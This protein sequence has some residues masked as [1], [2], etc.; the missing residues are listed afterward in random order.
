MTN[1]LPYGPN[2]AAV[3]RFLQ[4]FA[5]LD[6]AQWQ[7]AADRFTQLETTPRFRAADQALAGAIERTDRGA[8]RDAVLGPLLQIVGG[9]EEPVAP[10][11]LSAALALVMRDVLDENHFATLFGA[12]APLV[13]DR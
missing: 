6:A 8:E 4:R 13:P 12:V 5:A 9:D 3:R 1:A 11:A 7:E 10:A 2:T